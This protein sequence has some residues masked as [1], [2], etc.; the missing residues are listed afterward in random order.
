MRDNSSI[1]FSF[2][3]KQLEKLL[4]FTLS[5]GKFFLSLSGVLE[6][7]N[8][9]VS[10]QSVFRSFSLRVVRV[11]NYMVFLQEGWPEG[12]DDCSCNH[13]Y[14]WGTGSVVIKMPE[15]INMIPRRWYM[16]RVSPRKK[17]ASI[18]LKTGMR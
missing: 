18:V 12:F 13:C 9:P 8:V 14:F 5:N 7:S 17:T 15:K 10:C 1:E 6:D 3:E 11:L 4:T 16:W 2:I